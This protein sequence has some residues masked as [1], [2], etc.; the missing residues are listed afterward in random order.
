MTAN[1]VGW[2]VFLQ[3][4]FQAVYG[5]ITVLLIARC[6]TPEA[7]GWYYSFLSYASI[8]TLFDLG[9]SVALVPFFARFFHAGGLLNRGVLT[10][11]VSDQLDLE[12]TQVLRWYVLI[13][14]AF[15]FIVLPTGIWF[16]SGISN[17]GDWRTWISPWG[18]LIGA[19]GIMLLWMPL[20]ALIEGAGY[21]AQVTRIRLV[22]IT[23]GSFA[24][25]TAL[26]LGSGYWAST[27]LAV[28]QALVFSIWL[29]C[30]WPELLKRALSLL[31]RTAA[32][33]NKLR[34]V[35]WRVAVAWVCAYLTSQIFTLMLMQMSG[36][37]VAGR[38]ALSLALV[39][40]AGVLA[41]SSMAGRV[42]YVGQA[43]AIKDW[44]VIERT[45][46][47]DLIFFAGFYLL[48]CLGILGV[49]WLF[50]GWDVL[51][52]F[53][54]LGQMFGLLFF[55]FT[56]YLLN[57]LASYIRAFLK[58]PFAKIYLIGTLI[59]LPCAYFGARLYSSEGVIWV[60]VAIAAFWFLP[61]AIRVFRHEL[62]LAKNA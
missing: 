16:F 25:W 26:Y 60:L 24:C 21:M 6:L 44:V 17:N 1:R 42:A 62:Q 10:R 12:L 2:L 59:A 55:T 22:Q 58:E 29:V 20:L 13:A 41:L 48:S 39:S 15:I 52:K 47:Q 36:P 49:F 3:R 18:I 30:F 40:M 53:L 19:T 14:L 33:Q 43:A 31:C 11:P 46:R 34:R 38:F 57:L 23:L 7:Q 5:L 32:N 45:L 8:Y 51:T 50:D 4:A 54:P 9:F 56:I 37:V 28:S 35:P 61:A 27:A